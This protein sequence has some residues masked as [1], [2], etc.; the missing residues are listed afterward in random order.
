MATPR[1]LHTCKLSPEYGTLMG[2]AEV[3]QAEGSVQSDKVS[4]QTPGFNFPKHT[5]CFIHGERI[6]PWSRALGKLAHGSVTGSKA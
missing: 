4:G 3:K 5:A 2:L 6:W 1:V